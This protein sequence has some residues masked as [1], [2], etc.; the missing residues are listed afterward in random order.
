[1]AIPNS[2][3]ILSTMPPIADF[4]RDPVLEFHR[5]RVWRRSA[6]V[7]VRAKRLQSAYASACVEVR[8]G[9]APCLLPFRRGTTRGHVS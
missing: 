2:T 6:V 7:C 3:H 5:Y 9:V 1:M 4:S 8:D